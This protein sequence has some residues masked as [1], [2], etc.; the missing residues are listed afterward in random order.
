MFGSS[1]IVDNDAALKLMAF[2]KPLPSLLS[3]SKGLLKSRREETLKGSQALL[4]QGSS[5]VH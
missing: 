2:F 1:N 4:S 3:F 5:A